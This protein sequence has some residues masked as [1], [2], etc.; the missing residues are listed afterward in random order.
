MN[1]QPKSEG[2]AEPNDR[3]H[4]QVQNNGGF[5]P[6]TM[7]LLTLPDGTCIRFPLSTPDP[8]QWARDWLKE[9][10][11]NVPLDPEFVVTL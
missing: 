8:M 9:N 7:Y 3:T 1:E 11:P 10:R 2:A 5:M 6:A 4:A